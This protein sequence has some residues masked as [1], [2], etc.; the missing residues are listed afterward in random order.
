MSQ[1]FD[2]REHYGIWDRCGN[3]R[4]WKK[5][6][7]SQ[8]SFLF[9]N[10]FDGLMVSA[11]P[12]PGYHG[13]PIEAYR[14]VVRNGMEC[15]QEKMTQAYERNQPWVK[16]AVTRFFE[17]L[18]YGVAVEVMEK[19]YH[20]E[21]PV[22]YAVEYFLK[23]YKEQDEKYKNEG[24]GFQEPAREEAL[25]GILKVLNIMDNITTGNKIVLKDELDEAL[26]EQGILEC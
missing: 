7:E 18:M 17:S 26:A 1:T 21:R 23:T 19:H 2:L 16:R 11:T 6:V 4:F 3:T 15:G 12:Y 5:R 25:E 20:K 24:S 13:Q 9:I 10:P 22:D 8:A 14:V